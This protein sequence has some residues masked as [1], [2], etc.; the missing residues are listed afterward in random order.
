MELETSVE[1]TTKIPKRP[2][3]TTDRHPRY[4]EGGGGS[5]KAFEDT[6]VTPLWLTRRKQYMNE[7]NSCVCEKVQ[8]G[9]GGA[10]KRNSK[11]M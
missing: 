4:F 9:V 7:N 11:K 6:R 2:S 5:H 3:K 1:I 8:Q 10:K